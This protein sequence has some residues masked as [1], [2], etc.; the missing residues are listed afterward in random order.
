VYELSS[1]NG[2]WSETII[3]EF[4]RANGDGGN[5]EAGLAADAAGN[6]YGTT[7]FGGSTA[8]ETY[9][10]VYKLT[11]ATGGGWTES[12]L[13]SFTGTG[14]DGGWPYSNLILD[15]AGNLYGTA[16]YGGNAGFGTV[17]EITP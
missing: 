9:G 16:S 17:F 11:P 10:T 3:Y 7:L 12:I 13:Y 2:T 6:L 8:T 1:S 14:G 5:P 4:T 15:T